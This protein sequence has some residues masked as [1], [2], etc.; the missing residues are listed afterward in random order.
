M[1]D[2]ISNLRA[3]AK[4]QL[5]FASDW[6]ADL[7]MQVAGDFDESRELNPD[8]DPLTEANFSLNE[9]IHSLEAARKAITVLSEE[10]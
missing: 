5:G 1:A 2:K 3:I 8:V 7:Q 10:T 9:A 6:I 4:M